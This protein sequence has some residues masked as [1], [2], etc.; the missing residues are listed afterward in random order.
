MA[1]VTFEFHLITDAGLEAVAEHDL[2]D[3]REA[4]ARADPPEGALILEHDGEPRLELADDLSAAV[5]N[6]CFDAVAALAEGSRDCVLYSRFNAEGNVV[7]IPRG[8]TVRIIGDETPTFTAPAE[9][10]LPALYDCGLRV[11]ALLERHPDGGAEYLRPAAERAR[12]AL[13]R[14]H[15]ERQ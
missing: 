2:D 15:G 3:H 4:F 14:Q 13:E 9:D 1:T 12:R 10:L 8:S 11:V 7:F 6:A 5:K